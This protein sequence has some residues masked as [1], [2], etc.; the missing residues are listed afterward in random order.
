MLEAAACFPSTLA[1]LIFSYANVSIGCLFEAINSLFK[2]TILHV[3]ASPPA[4]L[5][6]FCLNTFLS[7][8]CTCNFGDNLQEL[9]RFPDALRH[10]CFCQPCFVDVVTV[11]EFSV[12]PFV[13]TQ[14]A[15]TVQTWWELWYNVL[16]Y[17]VCP[18]GR[19][20]TSGENHKSGSVCV[21]VCPC[22]G[23]RVGV[24]VNGYC[25]R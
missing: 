21:S 23:V 6:Y 12:C 1:L 13:K 15:L 8:K 14:K 3:R 9:K 17:V 20:T 11:A 2:F 7:L 25:S 24:E 4:C 5:T 10:P 22:V 18:V 16:L 19:L